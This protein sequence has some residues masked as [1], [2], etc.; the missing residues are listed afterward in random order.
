MG[1]DPDLSLESTHMKHSDIKNLLEQ[2]KSM[3][4]ED[5]MQLKLPEIQSFR[6]L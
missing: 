3:W 4:P 1:G 2:L 5:K 6:Y